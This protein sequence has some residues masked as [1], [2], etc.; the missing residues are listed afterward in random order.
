MATRT[1]RF[2]KLQV[3]DP[4]N[5][6]TDAPNDFWQTVSDAHKPDGQESITRRKD[7]LANGTLLERQFFFSSQIFDLL[8]LGRPRDRMDWPDKRSKD[9]TDIAS[10]ASDETISEILEPCRIM[11][12]QGKPIIAVARSS[13]GAQFTAIEEWLTLVYSEIRPGFTISLTSWARQ[14]QAERLEKALGASTLEVVIATQRGLDLT[15]GSSGTDPV[16]EAA[17]SI[18]EELGHP[19]RIKVS[20]GVGN[21]KNPGTLANVKEAITSL[22]QRGEYESLKATLVEEDPQTREIKR[23]AVN[24]IDD[25]VALVIEVDDDDL[26][27]EAYPRVLRKAILDFRKTNNI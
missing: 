12:V 9:E 16:G 4:Y 26:P 21:I 1:V 27:D 10:L 8:Y 3:I 11:P 13:A 17:H 2:Y 23:N 24:F 7:K 6:V 14:D 15:A 22:F 25:Q 19:A 20:V 5:I 18:Q